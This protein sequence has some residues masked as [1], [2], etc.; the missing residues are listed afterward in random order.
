M[1][2]TYTD[3]NSLKT[4]E[5][6][7]VFLVSGMLTLKTLSNQQVRAVELGIMPDELVEIANVI[8]HDL[9]R[10]LKM[11]QNQAEGTL[12]LLPEDLNFDSIIDRL[13][14]KELTRA[15]QMAKRTK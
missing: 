8:T 12:Q 4:L 3:K 11:Y 1:D 14:T 2:T 7:A 10:L 5:D 13:K 6:Y 9:R 15:K